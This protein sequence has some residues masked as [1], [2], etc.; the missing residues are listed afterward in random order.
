MMD[1]TMDFDSLSK[2]GSGLG[3]GAVF[4]MDESTCM[5]KACMRIAQF[6]HME[7]CVSAH[8]AAK[9]PA[10]CTACCNASLPAT[11]AKAI[12]NC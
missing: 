4:V 7:S 8:P 3:S 12:S 1:C 5:V 6:Y 10:G 2:V 11:A 9:V